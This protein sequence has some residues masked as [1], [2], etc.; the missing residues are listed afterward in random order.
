EVIAHGIA[1][2]PGRTT[3]VGRIDRIPVIALQGAPDQAFAAWWTL[4]LPVL[5]RL[6]GRRPRKSLELP[7][8]R[9]IASGVGIAEIVL[10]QRKQ[11]AWVTLAVGDL[12]LDAIARAE[13]W[14]VVPGGAE[15]FAA[16]ATVDG[17]MLRE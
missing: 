15:G 17:Y 2:Q 13:A 16:G 8:A 3:A 4:A 10:L 1:L 5:D 7:L 11:G 12:S 6:S 14:L 9:K